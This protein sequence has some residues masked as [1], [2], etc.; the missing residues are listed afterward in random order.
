[1]SLTGQEIPND[2]EQQ[3][4]VSG[5][6]TEEQKG[7]VAWVKRQIAKKNAARLAPSAQQ[8]QTGF[9]KT[10]QIAL[11]ARAKDLAAI[12]ALKKK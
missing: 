12:E 4:A 1:M 8:F 6:V 7:F 9:E 3:A 10:Q 5:I 2:E 11:T